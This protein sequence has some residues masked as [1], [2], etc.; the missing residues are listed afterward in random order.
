MA[1]T[2][3]AA[4]PYT[5]TADVADTDAMAVETDAERLAMAAAAEVA[6]AAVGK[7]EE[8]EEET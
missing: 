1:E 2:A 3:A 7:E 5:D 4:A 8:Q 6:A